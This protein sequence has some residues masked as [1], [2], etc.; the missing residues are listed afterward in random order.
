[1]TQTD[2]GRNNSS[3]WPMVGLGSVVILSSLLL[4][5]GGLGFNSEATDGGRKPTGYPQLVSVE[6]L[7]KVA[8]GGELCAWV[9]APSPVRLAAALRQERFTAQSPSAA[10]AD[11]R[12]S[13]ALNRPPVR[14]IRDPY[15]TYSAV[16]VDPKNNEIVRSEERRVGKECRSRW[17]PDH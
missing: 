12:G 9:P 17:S 15:P 10:V 16:A 14:V 4:A 2:R 5:N 13:V 6:P 11:G 3:R 8:M 1:M 7:P